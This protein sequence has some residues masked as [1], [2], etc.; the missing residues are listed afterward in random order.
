MSMTKNLYFDYQASTPVDPE[1]LKTMLPFFCENYG[2]PANRTHPFGR[3]AFEAVETARKQVA[4]AVGA[5]PSEIVFTSGATESNNHC[6]KGATVAKGTTDCHVIT[7][8]IEH[9]SVIEACQYLKLR[10]VDVT[11]VKP[12]AQGIVSPEAIF[13]AITPKTVLV[14][15]M[16]ANNEIGTIQP[17]AMIGAELRRRGI[18]FH[19]DI[20]QS[21]SHERINLEELNLDLASWSSHKLYG[22]KGC[23]AL[24]VRTGI[25]LG[26]IEPLLHGGAHER[27]WR[28]GT[29]N[30]PAIVG[31]GKAS[32]LAVQKSEETGRLVKL[33]DRLREG[34]KKKFQGVRFNGHPDHHLPHNLSVTFPGI[35]AEDVLMQAPQVACSVGSACLT[36]KQS[37][38]H[39]LRAIGLDDDSIHSTLRYSI[40]RF[41]TEG[42]I[43]QVLA[44][45]SEVACLRPLHVT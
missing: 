42:D 38:S 1:V 7:S 22:P 35:V 29:L 25:R 40:G 43:D 11:F 9:A 44:I 41:T 34:L 23:G 16:F 33:R 27:G 24:Y 37:A 2:N 8:A 15:I 5:K 28:S 36:Q 14:S 45:L 39:V 20:T 26:S 4:S 31:F 13:A 6:I 19:S 3:A 12:D 30:V 21:V 32:E 10:G 17:I 18:M